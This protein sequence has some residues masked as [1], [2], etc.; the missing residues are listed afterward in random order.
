MTVTFDD[1]LKK[2]TPPAVDVNAEILV[3][4]FCI[5]SEAE[6]LLKWYEAGQ[7]ILSVYGV[8]AAMNS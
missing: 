3:T 5:P 6:N 1:G 4:H 2:S 7:G 8:S